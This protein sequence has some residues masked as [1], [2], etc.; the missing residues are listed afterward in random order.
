MSLLSLSW[1]DAGFTVGCR[2]DPQKPVC[3]AETL[4][5]LSVLDAR[6]AS[7]LDAGL[8]RTPER[9]DDEHSQA[10]ARRLAEAV[11]AINAQPEAAA[12]LI[13]PVDRLFF[14]APS[15]SSSAAVGRLRQ[16]TTSIP[17]GIRARAI[18][19]DAAALARAPSLLSAGSRYLIC[20]WGEDLQLYCVEAS[21][22]PTSLER[23]SQVVRLRNAGLGSIEDAIL[24]K[25]GLKP[26]NAVQR[27]QLAAA[28]LRGRRYQALSSAQRPLTID[29]ETMQ[30][31]SREWLHGK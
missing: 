4:V 6:A 21:A 27:K 14:I 7:L 2:P 1:N 8:D 31:L 19:G 18:G 17:G 9:A 23:V 20:N 12:V 30:Q 26:A 15:G 5:D 16:A 29:A 25:T 24:R 3:R 13:N 22:D 28:F 10:L 11:E